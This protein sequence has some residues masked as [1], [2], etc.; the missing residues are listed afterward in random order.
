M[1]ASRRR[2]SWDGIKKLAEKI[3]RPREGAEGSILLV[4]LELKEALAQPGCPLC[5]LVERTER[6]YLSSF[7]HEN[8]LDV[9]LREALRA[10]RGFC[11]RHTRMLYE[12][13]QDEYHDHMG[14]AIVHEDLL[15]RVVAVLERYLGGDGTSG[16]PGGRQ[17]RGSGQW[18]LPFRRPAAHRG[19]ELVAAFTPAGVCPACAHVAS[20]EEIYVHEVVV[21]LEDEDFLARLRGSPGLCLPHFLKVVQAA[22]GPAPATEGRLQALI[23]IQLDQARQLRTEL[24]EYLRKHSYEYAHEPKGAETTSPRRAVEKMV[25]IRLPPQNRR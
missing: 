2:E 5:R 17:Q 3:S 14:T 6:R 12:I 23:E 20:M 21:H 25:G 7:L 15:G 11:P 22:A 13:E 24:G 10:A 19:G 16:E 8:V 4:Y 18:W 9:G 1:T